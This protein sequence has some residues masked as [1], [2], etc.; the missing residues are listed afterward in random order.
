[1]EGSWKGKMGDGRV[2]EGENR[3]GEEGVGGSWEGKTGMEKDKKWDGRVLEGEKRGW[4]E[5]RGGGRVLGG[6]IVVGRILEGE[7]GG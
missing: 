7:N 6:K 5:R 2:L 1:M 3:R 4:E